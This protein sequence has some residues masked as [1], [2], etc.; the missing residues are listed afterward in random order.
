MHKKWMTSLAVAALLAI[1]PAAFADD[2]DDSVD[3]AAF[4]SLA[5]QGD[6][7]AQLYLGFIYE[8]GE[9][10]PQD[11]K[12]A[13]KWYSLA[14][15]QGDA[16]AQGSLGSMYG[17]GKGVPQDYRAAVKWTRLAAEQGHPAAQYNLALDY[18]KGDGVIQDNV[19]AHMWFNIAASSGDSENAS[20]GRDIV[21]GM[22]TTAQIA[23]AQ[24]LARQCVAKEYKGCEQ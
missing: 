11:Y 6:A 15:E 18:G 2:V 4:I 10:V 23:E 16:D 19:Y 20:E 24:K 5:E 9:G 1:S 7:D 3:Y 14:A 8:K 17:M 12:A 13:M 22:M 21:A